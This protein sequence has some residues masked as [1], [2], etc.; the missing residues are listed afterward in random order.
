MQRDL[1]CL[2]VRGIEEWDN[3]NLT[4]C[5]SEHIT[6]LRV[7]EDI[8]QSATAKMTSQRSSAGEK[9]SN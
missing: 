2:I 8:D 5:E 3:R 1:A 4:I 9:Q 7:T 6:K